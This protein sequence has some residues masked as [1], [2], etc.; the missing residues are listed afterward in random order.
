MRIGYA[1]IA[2][3]T[4]HST[5]RRLLLKHFSEEKFIDTLALNLKDLIEILKYN[6]KNNVRLFRISSDIVPF[7]SHDINDVPWAKIF[8]QELNE[9]GQYIKANDLRVSMHPGQYTVL[10]SPKEDVVINAIRDVEYHTAFLDALEVDYTSKIVLHIGGVYGNKKE[11]ME[12]FIR[13]FHRLSASAKKR[14]I[15]ENDERS[16]N[17]QEV[18]SVSNAIHIP[19]VFDI[20]HHQCNPSMSEEV[21][22]ILKEVNATWSSLDGAM[23]LHYSDAAAGK[24]LGAHSD[25]VITNNF[26]EFYEDVAVYRPDIMLE[27]KD[28]DL[29]ALKCIHVMEGTD[30][31]ILQQQWAK[32]KYVVMEK[33][34]RHYKECSSII[35]TEKGPLAFYSRIDEALSLP[36]DQGSYGNTLE[37]AWSYFKHKATLKEKSSFF[38]F[39][40][41][42]DLI[43]AKK[44]LRRLAKKY[45][46]EYLLN[47]Y[48][49]LNL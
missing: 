27:V 31:K 3:G 8:Q 29:S 49:F 40:K 44:F 39:K 43:K 11:A 7:G 2:L 21:L 45:K 18:L 25:F 46:E 4:K 41:S 37:H 16:F 17:I 9:I 26:K 10:N 12:N 33:S 23:K 42:G 36:E 48:Y 34:Y 14:L 30:K 38:N 47:S 28:K 24:K 6:V 13:N 15:I 22:E 1:C 32:Y 19:V 5:N 35:R 20:L